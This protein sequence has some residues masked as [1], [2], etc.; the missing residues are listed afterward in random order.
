MGLVL[1]SKQVTPFALKFSNCTKTSSNTNK[2][3][4]GNIKEGK[5]TRKKR[6]T[7]LDSIMNYVLHQAIQ[8][9]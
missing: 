2:L 8:L 5:E 3:K 4:K 6:K 1:M 7:K 9:L